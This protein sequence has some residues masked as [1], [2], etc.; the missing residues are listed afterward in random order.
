MKIIVYFVVSGV[1]VGSLIRISEIWGVFARTGHI[2]LIIVDVLYVVGLCLL[3]FVFG[4]S[5]RNSN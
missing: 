5:A 2:D 1:L 3:L 4:R